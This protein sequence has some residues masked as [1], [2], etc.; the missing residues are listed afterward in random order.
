MSQIQQTKGDSERWRKDSSFQMGSE[1]THG[2]ESPKFSFYLIYPRFRGE[3][4]SN[5]R[6]DPIPTTVNM[7]Q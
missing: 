3:E 6:H 1:K 5:R 4:A 7:T 2:G